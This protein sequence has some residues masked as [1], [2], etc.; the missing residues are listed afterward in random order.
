ML[1]RRSG[2]GPA[3]TTARS[4]AIAAAEVDQAGRGEHV[5]GRSGLRRRRAVA[6]TERDE[7]VLVD[8]RLRRRVVAPAEVDQGLTFETGRQRGGRCEGAGA[9]GCE[10]CE[11]Q[12]GLLH[13]F[14]HVPRN[15]GLRIIATNSYLS[16][17][18][19]HMVLCHFLTTKAP[20]GAFV[21]RVSVFCLS[22]LLL[23]VE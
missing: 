15:C 17:I 18:I 20:Y 5:A 21:Y 3:V 16:T 6:A 23:C 7:I 2:V 4:G 8:R 22:S 14:L 12:P 9:E 1:R 11:E 10:C 13:G 19:L